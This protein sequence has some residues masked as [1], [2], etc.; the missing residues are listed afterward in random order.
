MKN[1]EIRVSV[2]RDKESGY[3]FYG[4]EN[5]WIQFAGN[6][7][8]RSRG[9]ALGACEEHIERVK[10]NDTLSMKGRIGRAI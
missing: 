10:G 9:E 8:Y 6:R 5:R 1:E 2:Y 7:G 3:W 4:F